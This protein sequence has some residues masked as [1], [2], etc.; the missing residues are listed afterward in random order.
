[1][2]TVRHLYMVF[3]WPKNASA[4]GSPPPKGAAAAHAAEV[5]VRR[6]PVLSPGAARRVATQAMARADQ[7]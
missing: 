5:R 2:N 3:E 6:V 7:R 1:M 4:W